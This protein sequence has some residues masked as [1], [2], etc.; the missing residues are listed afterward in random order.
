MDDW[1]G[2]FHR[3]LRVFLEC[4]NWLLPVRLRPTVRR[5]QPLPL[6]DGDDLSIERTDRYGHQCRV[7]NFCPMLEGFQNQHRGR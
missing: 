4:V 7:G 1:V 6:S 2:S 3:I 5:F